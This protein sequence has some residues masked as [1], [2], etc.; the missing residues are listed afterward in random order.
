M[1]TLRPYQQD[2]VD[3]IRSGMRRHK[4]QLLQLATGGGKTFT[5]GD[6]INKA[7][8]KGSS[9]TFLVPR[10]E[11]LKQTAESFSSVGIPFGYIA[12]GHTPNPR[13]LVQL[14]TVGTLGNRLEKL[15]PPDLMFIDETHF[16]SGQLDNIIQWAKD[17]GAYGIGLSGTPSRTDGKGLGMW[18]D[19]MIEGPSVSSLMDMGNLNRYT[20]YAPST[21]DLTGIRTVA[22]DYAKGQLADKMEGDRVL[23]GSSVTHYKRLAMGYLAVGFCVS[24]KHAEIMSEAFKAEGIPAGYIHGGMSDAERKAVIMAFARREIWVLFSCNL[25]SFGFDLSSAAQMNVTVEAII[26]NQP[27]QSLAMQLQKWGRGLRP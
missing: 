21:P 11:L 7:R 2:M 23:V 4:W 18:Y 13:H 27:T 12:A 8:L 25:L 19:N 6:M 14:A 15:T 10:R 22:G 3:R 1:I 5:A 24:V 16:G 26:D 20:A 17:G 9:C